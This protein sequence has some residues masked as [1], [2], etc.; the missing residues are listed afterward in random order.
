[1]IQAGNAS[2]IATFI[3]KHISS[4]FQSS[5][6][7]FFCLWSVH[8]GT[9]RNKKMGEAKRDGWTS[10]SGI[11]WSCGFAFAIWHQTGFLMVNCFI[12]G[13]I[14]LDQKYR[15]GD[16]EFV[17]LWPWVAL[18]SLLRVWPFLNFLMP[19]IPDNSMQ[20]AGVIEIELSVMVVRQIVAT[21]SAIEVFSISEV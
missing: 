17:V 10:L 13:I 4:F 15:P 5:L 19:F 6:M 1:M 16:N 8:K 21:T 14:W 9:G 20:L 3:Y 11:T 2:I 18:R 7:Q 12:S